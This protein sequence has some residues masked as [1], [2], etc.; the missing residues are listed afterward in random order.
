MTMEIA[1]LA[2]SAIISFVVPLVIFICILV[3]GQ[4]KKLTI[5]LFF[6]VGAI[7]YIAMQKGIKEHGLAWLFNHTDFMDFMNTHYIPY[8]LVVAIAGSI[9]A[10]GPVLL[11]CIIRKKQIS[12][13]EGVVLGLGY[14]MAES[15]LLVGNRSVNTIIEFVKGSDMKLNSTVTE[16]FL[17]GYERI[18]LSV[19]QIAIFIAFIYF[20]EQN[21]M[22]RGSLIAVFSH[23]LAAFLPGFFIAFSLKDY[24]EVYD[25]SLALLLIYIVLTAAALTSAVILYSL[26]YSVK[27]R[28]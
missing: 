12:F 24:Y 21:M 8:L 6:I 11:V 14:T 20:I 2:T 4:E 1:A 13:L 9:L 10:L 16:L 17:A 3:K 5:L 28:R 23:T 25:R 7:I 19:I 22:W 15:V 18:L 26:R 27:G